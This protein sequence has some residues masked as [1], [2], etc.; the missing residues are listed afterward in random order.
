MNPE[1]FESFEDYLTSLATEL[2]RYEQ[3]PDDVLTDIVNRDGACMWLYTN[4]MVPEWSCDDRTDRQ[5]AAG[6]CA[7]CPVRLPCLELELRTAG[8]FTL[9]VWGALSEEDRRALYPV[10]LARRENREGGEQE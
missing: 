9:G 8:L 7:D 5:L 3:V 10:W 4:G 1:D 2:D 6:I